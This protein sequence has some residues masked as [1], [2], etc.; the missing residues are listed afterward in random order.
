MIELWTHQEDAAGKMAGIG[1]GALFFDMGCGKSRTAL[2]LV[3]QWGC[4]RVLI[5]CPKSVVSVWPKEF[6]KCG[7]TDVYPIELADGT[8]QKRA[9]RIE[10]VLSQRIDRPVAAVLN[11]EAAICQPLGD[12]ELKG[13]AR[14]K[15]Q[16]GYL[17][18]VQ[19]DCL[20]CDE[21]HMLKDPHGTT[22]C[23]VSRL[24]ARVPHRLILTGTPMPH[25]PADIFAQYRIADPAIFGWSY[26]DFEKRYVQIEERYTWRTGKNGVRYKQP[27]PKV[28]GYKNLDELHEK[29]YRIAH[30]VMA[31]EVLDLPP[32]MDVERYCTLGVTAAK[33][34]A[35]ER[36]EF[37]KLV[38]GDLIT[39]SNALVRALRQ[40][41]IT[42]GSLPN[43]AVVGREKAD[44]LAEFFGEIAQD[45]PVVV[46]CH[47]T[48]DLA[49][50]HGVA[51]QCGRTSCELSGKRN[52]LG[53]WQAGEYNAIAVQLQAGGVGV[54][55]TRARYCV[56]YSLDW[57]SGNWQQTRKRIHR[58]GQTRPVLY[59]TLLASGTIDEVAYRALQ[60]RRDVSAAIIDHAR[61]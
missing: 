9:E 11:Y 23:F 13:D 45:E 39:D 26:K 19:W 42:S 47:F 44:M 55:F 41:Q 43:G 46:F 20:I 5:L 14:R 56:Y 54:D 31:D 30:R 32:V 28:V 48:S 53:A 51:T 38:K 34:Y 25:S 3:E 33:A 49:T 36:G 40:S 24:A 12:K 17:R 59:V 22:A 57:D 10:G 58:P 21:S 52:D 16:P 1:H 27:Y 61:A 7:L 29:V 6:D 4:K 2:A 35:E 37:T 15:W 50:V 18:D 60:E 8:V